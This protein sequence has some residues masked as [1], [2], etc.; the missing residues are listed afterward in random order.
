MLLLYCCDGF[1]TLEKEMTDQKNFSVNVAGKIYTFR[2]IGPFVTIEL[3]RKERATTRT[4]QAE[5]TV[6]DFRHPHVYQDTQ[7]WRLWHLKDDP[8]LIFQSFLQ[9]SRNRKQFNNAGKTLLVL[10]DI[11]RFCTRV[12]VRPFRYDVT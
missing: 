1:W 9:E 8:R 4:R 6:R 5:Q 12:L 3:P 2:A 11:D 7:D 10:T